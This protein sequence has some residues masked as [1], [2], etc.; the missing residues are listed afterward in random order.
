MLLIGAALMGNSLLKLLN[1]E[2]GADP[3][4]LLT[5]EFRFPQNELMRPVDKYRGV[6]LWEIFPVTGLTFERMWERVQA[7]PGVRSAAAISRAP[8]SGGAMGMPFLIEGRPLP[9]SGR[10]RGAAYFAITPRYFETMKI[11]ILRGRDFTRSDTASSALVMIINKTMADRFWEGKDPIGQHVTLDFVPNEQPRV[12]V[13]VVGDSVIGR[14]QRQPTPFMYVPHLQQQDRWQGP[15][16]DYRAMMAFVM[17]TDGDPMALAP[18]VRRAVADVDRS[19]PAGNIRTVEQYLGQQAR[20][21]ELYATLLGIFG[22]AAGLLAALGIYGVMAYTVAQR[23]R[24]IGIR[25]ALGAG[26]TR[27]MR[28]VILR[29]LVLIAIG[30]VLGLGGALGLTRVLASELYEV[31]PT[32]PVTFTVVTIG[33][34]VVALVACLIPTRRAMSVNPIVALRYE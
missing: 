28:L 10:G 20:G 7:I 12:I 9:E 6:G 30:L 21:L 34:T 14:F 25:M 16:W 32:D 18:A 4:N 26:G 33:L 1:N 11:P 19:K 3:K 29:A 8:L 5:F 15:A 22:V 13:G 23:T 27:V 24:E 17:R 31:S 2:L